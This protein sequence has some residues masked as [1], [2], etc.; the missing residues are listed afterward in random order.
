MAFL[1]NDCSYKGKRSGISGQCPACGSF[2]VTVSKRKTEEEESPAK[3]RLVLLIF[4]WSFLI[5]LIIWKLV[6]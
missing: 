6:S 2:N 1:C 5:L 3:W 4:L